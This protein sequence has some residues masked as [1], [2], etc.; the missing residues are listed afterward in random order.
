MVH[1]CGFVYAAGM[2][3]SIDRKHVRPIAQEWSII[4]DWIEDDSVYLKVGPD[5]PSTTA[6]GAE[7]APEDSWEEPASLPPPRRR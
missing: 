1:G 3:R 4:E 2:G 6:P 5:R 7:F